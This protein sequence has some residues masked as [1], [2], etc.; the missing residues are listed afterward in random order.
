[1]QSAY[2]VR[3]ARGNGIGDTAHPL[4]SEGFTHTH[5]HRHNN[6]IGDTADLLS[7][8]GFFT[9]V[10]THAATALETQPTC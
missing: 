3:I 6:G 7:S 8:E 10:H 2:A 5:T 9:C 1:V 4:S